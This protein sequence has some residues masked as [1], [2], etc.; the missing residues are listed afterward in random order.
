MSWA[1]TVAGIARGVVFADG[2]SGGTNAAAHGGPLLLVDP[3]DV[4]APVAAY[5]AANKATITS[6]IVYGGSAAIDDPTAAA[7]AGDAS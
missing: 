2:L 5:P 1:P 4:P 6:I 3:S 7:A